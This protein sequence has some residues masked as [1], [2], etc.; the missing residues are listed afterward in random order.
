MFVGEEELAALPGVSASR[1][2]QIV[3]GAIALILEGN[4]SATAA[5]VTSTLK[6]NATSNTI[7]LHSRSTTYGTPNLF[8]YTL[9]FG[10]GSGAIAGTK[11]RAY[12]LACRV[13]AS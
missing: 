1:A 10:G 12:W 3:A 9:N 11:K 13:G 4:P 2:H 8:L 5:Q 6:S 7:S